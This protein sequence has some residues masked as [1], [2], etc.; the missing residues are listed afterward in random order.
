MKEVSWNLDYF[1]TQYENLP[2]GAELNH[3]KSGQLDSHP[4]M[5]PGVFRMKGRNPNQCSSELGR[6]TFVQAVY[7][8]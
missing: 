6:N 4:R 8:T 5:E 1:K 2:G 7:W 3:I